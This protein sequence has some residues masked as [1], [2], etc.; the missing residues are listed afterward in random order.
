MDKKDFLEHTDL[1]ENRIK[2]ELDKGLS[3]LKELINNDT[4]IP[5]IYTCVLEKDNEK[6]SYFLFPMVQDVDD[7]VYIKKEYYELEDIEG[8]TFIGQYILGSEKFKFKFILEKDE[9]FNEQVNILY[10]SFI[11]SNLPWQSFDKRYI[12]RMYRVKILEDIDYLE[13]K[14]DAIIDYGLGDDYVFNMN[15]YWNIEKIQQISKKSLTILDE[16]S[17]LYTLDKSNIDYYLLHEDERYIDD[18][19]NYED[20]VKIFSTKDDLYCFNIL[21]VTK[22]DERFISNY[23]VNN[24]KLRNIVSLKDIVKIF[25]VNYGITIKD[26]FYSNENLSHLIIP[27]YNKQILKLKNSYLYLK[28]EKIQN[29]DDVIH[30]VNYLNNNL[31]TYEVRVYG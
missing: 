20:N 31:T 17:Y 15:I 18:V 23:T 16:I 7:C 28:L 29:Y 4:S 19:L 11:L 9:R 22:F 10:K 6:Y 24:L 5:N 8:M 13:D 2:N 1:F 26:L 25:K 30:L 14:A 27:D 3:H 12:N 21:R